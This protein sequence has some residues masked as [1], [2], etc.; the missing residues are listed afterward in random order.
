MLSSLKLWST[1]KVKIFFFFFIFR[2]LLCIS[3]NLMIQVDLFLWFLPPFMFLCLWLTDSF[4]LQ[5]SFHIGCDYVTPYTYA[6]LW[7]FLSIFL[8]HLSD[9]LIYCLLFQGTVVISFLVELKRKFGK[10]RY[11]NVWMWFQNL[12]LNLCDQKRKPSV[13]YRFFFPKLLME[14]TVWY[15]ASTEICCDVL[16]GKEYILVFHF[17]SKYL[18]FLFPVGFVPFLHIC[19][20]LFLWSCGVS[21]A[22]FFFS[23]FISLHRASEFVLSCT[24]TELC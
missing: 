12:T 9:I 10:Y 24:G 22:A 3:H 23:Y 1:A 5:L 18:T 20:L 7:T 13:L 21:C 11:R 6:F 16:W 2:G 8:C 14:E 17:I 19:V 4:N 15:S